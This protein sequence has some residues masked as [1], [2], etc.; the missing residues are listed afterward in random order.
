ML[1]EVGVLAD[2]ISDDEAVDVVAVVGRDPLGPQLGRERPH[3]PRHQRGEEAILEAQVRQNGA[4]TVHAV[5]AAQGDAARLEVVQ[6]RQHRVAE[7]VREQV[8]RIHRVAR[9][10]S[11]HLPH[12]R[13][14]CRGRTVRQRLP[15][16]VLQPHRSG[17]SSGSAVASG[18]RQP[19]DVGT[20]RPPLLPRILEQSLVPLPPLGALLVAVALGQDGGHLVPEAACR[21]QRP[22]RA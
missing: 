10:V 21:S 14:Q 13:P 2:P 19:V 18:G 22:L 16:W 12:D 20:P 15:H 17:Q 1:R 9:A 6:L 7:S 8:E 3:H 5:R 4:V 11:A